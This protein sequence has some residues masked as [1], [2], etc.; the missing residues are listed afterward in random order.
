[1]DL[2]GVLSNSSNLLRTLFAIAGLHCATLKL[3]RD[4]DDDEA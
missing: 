1:M 2:K 3:V 4:K